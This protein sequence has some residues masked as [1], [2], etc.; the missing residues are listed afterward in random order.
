MS[1]FVQHCPSSRPHGLLGRHAR[2]RWSAHRSAGLYTLCSRHQPGAPAKGLCS[3]AK[4]GLTSVCFAT[5]SSSTNLRYELDTDAARKCLLLG[6]RVSNKRQ[7]I[8]IT[9]VRQRSPAWE[10][11]IRPGDEL[12]GISDPNV[13]TVWEFDEITSFRF[14]KDALRMRIPDTV[15]FLINKSPPPFDSVAGDI[16]ETVGTQAATADPI[17]SDGNAKDQFLDAVLSSVESD[18]SDVEDASPESVASKLE[19]KY[20]RLK[21]EKTRSTERIQARKAALT[22]VKERNDAPFFLTVL[23]VCLA[24]P[25]LI[26]IW[27]F[28]SG[29]LDRLSSMY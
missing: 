16:A 23:A 20:Q 19:R 12:V 29:Y 5:T 28:S 27:A 17:T 14:V 4:R 7:H 25:V 26:L 9:G 22:T 15:T 6:T 10:V 18:D 13:D 11:G 2:K 24:P 1:N 21:T 8:I 3:S